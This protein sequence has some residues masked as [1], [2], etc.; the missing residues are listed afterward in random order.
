[1]T[2]STDCPICLETKCDSLCIQTS[3]E[4]SLCKDCYEGLKTHAKTS[5]QTLSCPY[6]RAPIFSIKN[7]AE[8]KKEKMSVDDYMDKFRSFIKRAG[9][10]EKYHQT[11]GIEWCFKKETVDGVR[12][13]IIADE[14][15]LGKTI[16]AIGLIC[17]NIQKNTLVVVPPALLSQWVNVIRKF[18]KH[19]PIIYHGAERFKYTDDEIMSNPLV[20]TTYS[21]ISVIKKGGSRQTRKLHEI[22]WGRVIYDESHHLRNKNNKSRGAIKLNSKINWFMSGTPVQN[23][24]KDVVNYFRILK[25]KKQD[26]RMN[27]DE[28]ENAISS[29]TLRRTKSQANIKLPEIKYHNVDVE[30][31]SDL[32]RKISHDIHED[33]NMIPVTMRNVDRIM[34][35]LGCNTFLA[36]AC[37]ARQSCI[38]TKMLT[39]NPYLL[40]SEEGMDIET[41]EKIKTINTSSKLDAV[42]KRIS[43]TPDKKCL[44]FCHFRD[45]IDYLMESFTNKLIHANFID[46]RKDRNERKHIFENKPQVLILQIK[47][48]CEGLNLQSYQQIHFTSNQWNPAVEDQAIARC[49]RIGQTEPVDVFNYSMDQFKS[50]TYKKYKN[51]EW[52]CQEVQDMKRK[53][54][55]VTGFTSSTPAF[56]D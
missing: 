12:G 47:T 49:H 18:L 37:R 50:G 3:C 21:Q 44:V 25:V 7:L 28:I 20:I 32:E 39:K 13:G 27:P 53:H 2:S 38:F 33:M 30:W 34:S 31:A 29:Y 26:E 9:L 23:K 10:E 36:K 51:F 55:A 11:K 1:M 42:V 56:F 22:N 43:S 35:Y 52:Y 40:Q 41:I 15:G 8:A 48:C 5:G 4:H 45:E 14:M 6:C 46:G 17:C 19:N 54:M 16:L 24:I